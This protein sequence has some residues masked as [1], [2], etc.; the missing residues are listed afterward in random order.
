LP[1]NDLT[2]PR[3]VLFSSRFCFELL[4]GLVG[5]RFFAEIPALTINA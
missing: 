1:R 3:R 2:S 5:V 4:V